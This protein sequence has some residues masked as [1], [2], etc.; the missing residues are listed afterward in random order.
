MTDP[1]WVDLTPPRWPGWV[2]H[3]CG[4]IRQQTFTYTVVDSELTYC[5]RTCVCGEAVLPRLA[6]VPVSVLRG[7]HSGGECTGRGVV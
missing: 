7:R 5:D 4:R 2:C 3:H 6:I 1:E